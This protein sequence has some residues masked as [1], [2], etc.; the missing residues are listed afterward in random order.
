M[1]QIQA[2]I[3][4]LEQEA[5]TTRR[6]LERVPAG[7]DDYRPHAKSMPLAR[8]AGHVAEMPVWGKLTMELAELDLNPPGGEPMKGFSSGSAQELVEFFE[9]SVAEMRAALLAANDDELSKPWTLKGGE[10]I[11]FT[12]PKGAVLRS[13]VYSHLVHHR[14][15]LGV[16]LRLNDIPVPSAYGPTADEAQ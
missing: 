7:R 16:Y 15:Q 10:Q 11:Y 1:S 14:A 6:Y 8:L 3:E 2:L 13:F 9:R 4:E 12:M 5:A